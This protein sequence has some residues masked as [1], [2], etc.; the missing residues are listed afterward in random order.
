MN[1]DLAVFIVSGTFGMLILVFF[2]IFFIVSYQKKS[3][4]AQLEMEHLKTQ[5]EKNATLASFRGQENERQRIAKDLHDDISASLTATKMK[6][7]FLSK[8]IN[9]NEI[10]QNELKEIKNI[11]TQSIDGVRSISQ[12]L[13]P[14]ALMNFG[15]EQAVEQLVHKISSPPDFGANFQLL[16]NPIQIDDENRLMIYRSIQEILI[17]SLKHS[18]A[19]LV[20]VQF[21]W[22]PVLLSITIQDNG[23]GFDYQKA[24]KDINTGLGLKNIESRL[25]LAGASYRVVSNNTGTQNFITLAIDVKSELS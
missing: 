21:N 23:I 24:M 5:S 9:D 1:N 13:M 22:T 10:V 16:G 4:K 2:I 20:E 15:L 8:K 12:N 11:L 19:T 25:N 18:K 7:N 17:N 14:Y 6:V 3:F